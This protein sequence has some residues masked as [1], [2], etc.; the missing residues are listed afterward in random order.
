MRIIGSMQKSFSYFVYLMVV[1]KKFGSCHRNNKC[2]SR[3]PYRYLCIGMIY[4]HWHKPCQQTPS[5]LLVRL[6]FSSYRVLSYKQPQYEIV[7]R[8][9]PRTSGFL[10]IVNTN[11]ESSTRNACATPSKPALIDA[12][13]LST[14]YLRL[15][16]G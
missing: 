15:L 10:Q 2:C 12:N 4:N 1:C 7:N 16:G 11:L 3:L 6:P 9:I 8:I 5:Q 14:S 13:R